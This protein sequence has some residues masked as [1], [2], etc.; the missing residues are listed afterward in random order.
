MD[1][2]TAAND[3]MEAVAALAVECICGDEHDCRSTGC[4]DACPACSGEDTESDVCVSCGVVYVMTDGAAG[5][6]P[7]CRAK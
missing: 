7:A 6:C 3:D 1:T 4:D 5:H 2:P